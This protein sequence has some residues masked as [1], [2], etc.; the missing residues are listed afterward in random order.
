MAISEGGRLREGSGRRAFLP[1]SAGGSAEKV[2]SRSCSPAIARTAAP[3]ARL[4]GSEGLSGFM[5]A[6]APLRH[7]HLRRTLRKLFT[8]GALV[9]F[10]DRCPLQFVARVEEGKAEGETDVAEDLRVLRQSHHRA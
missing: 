8:E 4:N 5:R 10:R 3:T 1:F 6:G 7:Q 2:T 9:E